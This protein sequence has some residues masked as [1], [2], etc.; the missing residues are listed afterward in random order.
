MNPA[1]TL[2]QC[3]I[4]HHD[5]TSEKEGRH[6]PEPQIRHIEIARVAEKARDV[7][8]QTEVAEIIVSHFAL[9]ATLLSPLCFR[10]CTQMNGNYSPDSGANV[11][12][13]RPTSYL[14]RNVRPLGPSA[15]IV[16]IHRNT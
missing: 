16:S 13:H 1:G 3:E 11:L 15:I 12:Y 8:R 6:A 9:I 4:M 5:S 10:L 14:T 2:E 7:E